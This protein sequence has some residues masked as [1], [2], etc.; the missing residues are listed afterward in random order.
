MRD[1]LSPRAPAARRYCGIQQHTERMRVLQSAPINMESHWVKFQGYCR[2]HNF[3]QPTV[4]VLA[5]A[6]KCLLR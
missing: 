3:Y 1:V 4:A 6:A 5:V 2:R